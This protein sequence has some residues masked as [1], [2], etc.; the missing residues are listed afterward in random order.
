MFESHLRPLETPETTEKRCQTGD[1]GDQNDRQPV[2]GLHPT[3]VVQACRNLLHAET[4]RGRDTEQRADDRN[5]V[6]GMPDTAFDASASEQ[7]F[8]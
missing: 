4:E 8:E 2:A 1:T 5:R 6:D 3:E 7:W